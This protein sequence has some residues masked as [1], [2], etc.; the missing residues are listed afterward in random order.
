[1]GDY[2]YTPRRFLTFGGEEIGNHGFR[3]DDH[4]CLTWA[5]TEML[6]VRMGFSPLLLIA[7]NLEHIAPRCFA[8]LTE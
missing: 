6:I 2:C 7:K 8:R 4:A 3:S 5:K 1:M